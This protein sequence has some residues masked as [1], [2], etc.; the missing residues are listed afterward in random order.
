MVAKLAQGGLGPGTIPAPAGIGL[1]APHYIEILEAQPPVG[2][3]EVHSENHFGAGGK[4]LYYLERIR[5]HYPLSLHGVGL[6]LGSTDVL[7]TWHL[8]RLKALIQRV[9]PALV[10]DHLSWSSVGGRY[11]NDLLPLPYTEEALTHLGRRVSQVQDYLGRQLLLE[12]ISSYLHYTGSTMPEWDFIAA[13]SERSGCGLLLDVNN[14]YVS[15]CNQGFDP[16]V[17]LQAIPPAAVREIHLAGFTINRFKDGEMLIDTHNQR[18]APQVWA[19][20]HQA[21]QRLGN[22]PTL[23]EWD[24]DLPALE[25]LV[26]EARQAD[27]IAAEAHHGTVA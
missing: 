12:N 20:Y 19:L 22:R 24:T 25:V 11:L 23:I 10:S 26:A 6:S 3:L 21:V 15:A 7:N 13:L 9:E 8:E 4:P 16:V 18:V 27:R 1:R 2:W 14:L 5:A 17:Y